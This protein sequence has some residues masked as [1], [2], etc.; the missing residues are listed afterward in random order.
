MNLVI[1]G[2]IIHIILVDN[3]YIA[4]YGT[5]QLSSFN[6]I[7]PII[8]GLQQHTMRTYTNALRG[9]K[10]FYNNNIHKDSVVKKQL[11]QS[12]NEEYNACSLCRVDGAWPFVLHS[13]ATRALTMQNCT[14]CGGIVCAFCAPTG[15][16]IRGDGLQSIIK[17]PDYRI[18]VPA[19][20]HVEPQITC[21]RCF[22]NS[23]GL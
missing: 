17:L 7:L 11:L 19:L 1:P 18:T 4:S 5:Y 15:N 22:I 2:K 6:R 10:L 12:E 16:S 21:R 8:E 9:C 20:N 13:D 23:Y 14:I 3:K